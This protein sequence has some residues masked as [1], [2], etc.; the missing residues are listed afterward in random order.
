M[1]STGDWTVVIT[2]SNNNEIYRASP[3][4]PAV[5]PRNSEHVLV[6]DNGDHRW[7]VITA[8]YDYE[9]SI[10]VIKCRKVNDDPIGPPSDPA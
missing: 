10:A 4:R 8:Q 7:H 9:D 1:S 6:P 5:I 2:D 3:V